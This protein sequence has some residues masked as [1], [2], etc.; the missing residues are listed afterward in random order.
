MFPP[1][2]KKRSW[3]NLVRRWRRLTRWEFW[4]PY[5]FYPP[6]V[7]Y[8]V[9]LGIKHRNPVLFTAAN[10][11]IP[12]GGFVGES[13][14]E[15][16]DNLKRASEWLP[17]SILISSTAQEQRVAE[18]EEFMS[19]RGL[20]LPVVLKPD[21]GQRGSGVSVVRSNAQLR[22]YLSNSSFPV[23]VQEY[24][25]GDE[26]GVFYYRY[27]G[28]TLG[29]VFSITEKRMPVLVGDGHSTLEEL[30]LADDRALCMSE[31]YLNKNSHRAQQVPKAGEL[32][33]LVEIGTH[34][35]GAI[36][37]DAS[38]GITPELEAT[39]D[40]IAK[41]FDGF[42]FGRFDIRVPS[43]DDLMAGR[44]LKI[45]ELNGVTSEAT[46]IYDPKLSLF[47]AYRALFKQWRIAFEI[48]KLNRDRGARPSS[49]CE[50]IGMIR[51]YSQLSKNYPE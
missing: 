10:P 42:Y 36:F 50:L 39:I 45:L 48:G 8:I 38:D 24:V 40:R 28:E 30:I 13:K 26:F 23:I 15:I 41:N 37:L 35:R 21:A 2:G 34:C 29:H 1:A 27:P 14:H 44:R 22:E 16:L 9:S 6:V 25:S 11:A 5:F 20:Q 31:F 49:L 19:T 7:V 33:Q 43:R 32:M 3:P 12:A 46:H 18:A 4:P 47:D 51:D 17:A